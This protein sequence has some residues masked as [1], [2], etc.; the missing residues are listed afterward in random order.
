MSKPKWYVVWSGKTP[1]IYTSY[2]T[3]AQVHGIKGAK[4]QSFKPNGGRRGISVG[5][6]AFQDLRATVLPDIIENSL[7]VDAACSITW[8]LSTVLYQH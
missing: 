1:G 4:Y 3:K 2:D 6:E 8:Q 7:A 5:P